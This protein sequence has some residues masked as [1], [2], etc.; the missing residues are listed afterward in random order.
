MKKVLF[1]LAM[2]AMIL[3]V[4]KVQSQNLE[5]ILGQIAAA[6]TKASFDQEYVFD[7]YIQMEISDLGDQ[8]IVY[9]IHLTK[10]GSS[11]AVIFTDEGTKSTLVFDTK[12]ST[13]LMLS[14][15]DGEKTGV[16][17]GINAEALAGITDEAEDA[18]KDFDQYKTGK[19]KTL[20]GYSC[21]EY[22]IHEDGS[23]IRMWTSEKLGKAVEKE[24][25]AN[26]QL[27]GGAFVHAT[28]TNGMV[29]EYSLKDG[30]NGEQSIMTV[31]QIDLNA[32]NSI[33]VSEYSVMS[34]GQ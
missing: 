4:Q 21:E 14:E 25:F 1:A 2:L 32:N 8:N 31:T 20:L 24:V 18:D 27:F 22:L 9:D 16:A 33:I 26:Q 29:L 19:T 23:E 11:Y 12:N 6:T 5:D 34:L 30:N 13:M 10:D 28:A 7:T 15:E 17:M 3:S